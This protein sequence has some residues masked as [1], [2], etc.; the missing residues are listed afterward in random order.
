MA[1]F[2]K[3][4][5]I[6]CSP[7]VLLRWLLLLLVTHLSRCFCWSW[8]VL[9]PSVD[10]FQPLSL[11]HLSAFSFHCSGDR[12]HSHFKGSTLCPSSLPVHL[13]ANGLI[14][15]TLQFIEDPLFL[16]CF[17]L[18]PWTNSWLCIHHSYISAPT[19]IGGIQ[20]RQWFL[21]DL[22]FFL[23][24]MPGPLLCYFI[25]SLITSTIS[26]IYWTEIL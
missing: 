26:S 14:Q 22:F 9:E 17:C 8:L 16:G 15:R 3:L 23:S 2:F 13:E 20:V 18:R 19:W 4:P 1:S 11:S 5:S 12:R 7:L 21:I 10:S 24:T 25:S 6:C